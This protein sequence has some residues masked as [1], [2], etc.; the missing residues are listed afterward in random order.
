VVERKDIDKLLP[1]SKLNNISILAYS[2]LA[3]GVLSGSKPS[4]SIQMMNNLFT[5]ENRKRLEPL[6]Q[7]IRSIAAERG[8]TV[9][10]VALNWR[11]KDDNVIPIVGVK[12]EQH[13][14]DD[15]AVVGWRLTQEEI[16][17]IEDAFSLFKK[18]R[19]RSYLG[20]FSHLVLHR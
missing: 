18:E 16:S 12:R 19:I 17:K 14:E 5:S 6:L 11:L 10:Q 15:A 2:P 1:Y 20:M 3:Q 13:V 9:T 7:T 4:S 8:K